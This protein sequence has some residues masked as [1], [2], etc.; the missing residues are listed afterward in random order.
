MIQDQLIDRGIDDGRVL[1]AM[2][3]IPRHL[4]VA[5]DLLA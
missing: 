1:A 2:R 5:E 3:S 4:F